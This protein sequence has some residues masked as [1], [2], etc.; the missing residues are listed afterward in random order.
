M[1]KISV[2]TTLLFGSSLLFLSSCSGSK[3]IQGRWKAQD[4]SKSYSGII[5]QSKKLIIDKEDYDYTQNKMG[6]ENGIDYYGFEIDGEEFIII[7]PD[8]THK[9][10]ALFIKPSYDNPLKGQLIYALNRNDKPDYEEY[11][12]EYIRD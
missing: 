9:N 8:K 7:F 4:V 6:S 10:I 5:F 2:I 1:G 11:V 12:K 3:V